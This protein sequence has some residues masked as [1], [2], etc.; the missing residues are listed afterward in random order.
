MRIEFADNLS[1]PAVI[2]HL[3][4]PRLWVPEKAYPDYDDWLARIEPEISSGA[5]RHL[6]CRWNGDFGGVVVW[7]RHKTRRG[8]LEIKNLTVHPA[9]RGRLVGSFLL[10]QAEIEG[11]GELDAQAAVCGAK[12]SNVEMVAFLIARG[13]RVVGTEDLYGLGAG[14]DVILRHVFV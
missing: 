2:D 5:K 10:R 9:V 13:Y 7:Q 4:G 1:A 3:R 14:K 8:Y 12:R 6:V 11:I